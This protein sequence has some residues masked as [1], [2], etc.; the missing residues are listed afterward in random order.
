MNPAWY[1]NFFAGVAVDFWVAAAT[2]EWT[3]SDVELIWRELQLKPGDRVLDCPC[4]HGRHAVELARRGCRV[5]GIDISA[6]CLQLAGEAGQRAGISLD[7]RQADMQELQDLAGYDAAFTVGNA[8]GYFDHA[9]SLQFMRGIAAALRPGGRW[10]IDT[11]I[12]AESILATLKPELD[13][14]CGGITAKISNRY[15]AEESCFETTFTFT[16]DGQT[17]TRQNWSFVFTVAEIRR[18]LTAAGFRVLALYGG[19]TGEPYTVGCGLLYIVAEK[20]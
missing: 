5:T 11:G 8:F 10:L 18:M 9:G 7:L 12:A 20:E 1:R 4:G 15:L 17:E 2:P 19:P 3:Q 6:Y 14:T 13:Y 16:K